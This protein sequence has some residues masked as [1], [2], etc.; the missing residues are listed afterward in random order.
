[1]PAAATPAATRCSGWQ[2]NRSIDISGSSTTLARDVRQGG[3]AMEMA[4]VR[5]S[6]EID[7]YMLM[8]EKRC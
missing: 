3:W 2:R 1:M 7:G 6:H 8:P 4:S 5:L